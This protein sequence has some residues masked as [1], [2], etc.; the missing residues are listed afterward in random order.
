ML[1][2]KSKGKIVHVLSQIPRH[3]DVFI[4]LTKHHTNMRSHLFIQVLRFILIS[5]VITLCKK[6]HESPGRSEADR[7]LG[8]YVGSRTISGLLLL[9][10]L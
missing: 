3:E 10:V 1:D 7:A 5:R 9:D 6:P 8:D 2:H 4:A